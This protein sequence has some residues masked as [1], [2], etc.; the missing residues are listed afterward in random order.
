VASGGETG[1]P[2]GSHVFPTWFF[3]LFKRSFS[4]LVLFFQMRFFLTTVHAMKPPPT[5]SFLRVCPKPCSIS[6]PL[7]ANAR[8]RA[9]QASALTGGDKGVAMLMAGWKRNPNERKHVATNRRRK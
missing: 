8:T 3:S 7:Q 6:S 9:L 2:E 4:A 1:S 5:R